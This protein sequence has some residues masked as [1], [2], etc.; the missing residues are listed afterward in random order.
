MR[1]PVPGPLADYGE[2][3]PGEDAGA[4]HAAGPLDV[5]ARLLA[6]IDT[7]E[8]ERCVRLDRHGEIRRPLVPDRPRP[9]GTPAG[10]QL[11]DE[12]PVGLGVAKPE[13]VE[14][15]QVLGDHR[16]V[17][18][19][20]ALPPTVRM[21]QREQPLGSPLD[22]GIEGRELLN[23][24]QAATFVV[25]LDSSDCTADRPERTAPSIVAGQP[26]SVHAPA[27][28]MRS[29]TRPGAGRTTPGRRAI[30]ASGSRLTRDQSTS[31]SPNRSLTSPTM[32]A[33]SSLPRRSISS[34]T[35]LEM[36]V[37]Y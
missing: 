35:P 2:K 16:R 31:A 29:R 11:V 5:F 14:Q 12:Q 4:C 13:E 9:V 1:E 30:V 22:G 17:R 23:D 28:A 6:W 33:R 34:G 26:V 21:L 32:T 37:R 36:T 27:R 25:K 10:Q 15:E 20:L 18:L 19:E 24:G 3:G 7:R 8:L